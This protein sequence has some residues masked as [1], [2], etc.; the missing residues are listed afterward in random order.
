MV[1]GVIFDL[2]GVIVSTDEYHYQA[3]KKLA[4]REDIYFNYKINNRLR[5]VS[6][7]RS[8]EIILENSGEDYT[9][10]E[11]QEMAEYKNNIYKK[12]LNNL[13]PKDIFDNVLE[14][15]SYLRF[16]NISLAIGSSS[17]NT[18]KILEQ[19]DMLNL[20]DAIADGT[21]IKRSKPDPE[22]FQIACSRLGLKPEECIVVEDAIA[23]IEAAKKGNM[24]AVAIGDAKSSDL[25]DYKIDD[26]IQIKDIVSMLNE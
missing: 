2:D 11:K 21:D 26:I 12:L 1:R 17:K 16:K 7:M 3:W 19:I 23:G 9:E 8:L 6:R 5:G 22:V 18:K 4:D 24:I 20:F 15:L 10:E 25:A 14:L 13:T